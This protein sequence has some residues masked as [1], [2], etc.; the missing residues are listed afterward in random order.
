LVIFV[1]RGSG[2]E[3]VGVEGLLICPLVGGSGVVIEGGSLEVWSL[4]GGFGV[5]EVVGVIGVLGAEVVSFL[6]RI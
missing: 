5:T 1:E 3:I 2:I 6:L 4:I